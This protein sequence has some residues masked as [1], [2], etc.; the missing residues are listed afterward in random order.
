LLSVLIFSASVP[1]VVI[2]AAVVL[3]VI[4]LVLNTRLR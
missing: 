3:S 1:V 2:G 4:G